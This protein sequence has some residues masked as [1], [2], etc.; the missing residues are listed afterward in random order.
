MARSA[1]RVSRANFVKMVMRPFQRRIRYLRN[2]IPFS[3]PGYLV[4]SLL[5]A[6]FF[7]SLLLSRLPHIPNLFQHDVSRTLPKDPSARFNDDCTLPGCLM[8]HYT[9]PSHV[10]IPLFTCLSQ[11]LTSPGSEVGTELDWRMNERPARAIHF[12]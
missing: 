4:A 9:P 8:A 12:E 5:L 3:Y 7:L 10:T 2:F 1:P 11:D 6:S